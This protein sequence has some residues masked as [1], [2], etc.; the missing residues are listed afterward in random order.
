MLKSDVM[1]TGR[2]P[3]E[4]LWRLASQV[5]L[6]PRSQAPAEYCQCFFLQKSIWFVIC[7]PRSSPLPHHQQGKWQVVAS[8]SPEK[9]FLSFFEVNEFIRNSRLLWSF[10]CRQILLHLLHSH[11]VFWE[12]KKSEILWSSVCLMFDFLDKGDK[13]LWEKQC[14]LTWFL[15][16]GPPL[17][18]VPCK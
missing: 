11:S 3:A 16:R 15:F 10:F 2:K 18:A 6:P 4:C 13:G 1:K 7:R 9:V 14:S 12:E 17:L 8:A 5:A